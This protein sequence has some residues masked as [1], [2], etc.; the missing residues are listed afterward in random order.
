M[1]VRRSSYRRPVARGRRISRVS[2]PPLRRQV[3]LQRRRVNRRV[4]SRRRVRRS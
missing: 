3:P 1:Y 4:T 2:R